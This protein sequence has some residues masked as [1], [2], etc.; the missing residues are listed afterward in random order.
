MTEARLVT[1]E[2]IA[3]PVES[4]VFTGVKY[5]IDKKRKGLLVVSGKYRLPIAADCIQEFIKEL[6]AVWEVHGKKTV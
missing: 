6:Q 3:I 1:L 5:I 2:E 4:E